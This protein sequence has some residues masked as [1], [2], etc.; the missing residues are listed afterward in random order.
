MDVSNGRAAAERESED[1][2][3]RLLPRD[4]P[5]GTF[6]TKDALDDGNAYGSAVTAAA[7]GWLIGRAAIV[8]R[9]QYRRILPLQALQARRGA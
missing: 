2:P 6:S 8:K 9:P 1:I 7:G 3:S 5:A 4:L